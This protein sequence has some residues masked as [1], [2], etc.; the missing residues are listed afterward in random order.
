MGNDHVDTRQTP[1][2]NMHEHCSEHETKMNTL[3]GCKNDISRGKGIWTTLVIVLSFGTATLSFAAYKLDN[4]LTSIRTDV[5][6]I[7]KSL[8][9]NGIDV[10][11]LQVDMDNIKREVTELKH[12]DK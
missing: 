5:T 11:R 2:C 1:Y 3:D 8:Y 6:E 10:G 9:Q 7:R 12:E 4:T